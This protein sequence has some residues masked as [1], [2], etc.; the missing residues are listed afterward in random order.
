M[1]GISLLSQM[2]LADAA[3]PPQGNFLLSMLPLIL[4]VVIM[5][6]LMIRPQQ[7]KQKAQKAMIDSIKQGDEVVTTGGL[8]G[9]VAGVRAYEC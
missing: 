8:Y 6:F 7:K 1:N 2:T 4:I 5:Y 9:T 3:A